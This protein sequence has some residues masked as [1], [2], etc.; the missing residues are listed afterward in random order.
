V[1]TKL[2][3]PPQWINADHATV[4]SDGK[5]ELSFTIDPLSEL[6]HF[7]LEK[8]TGSGIFQQIA[9]PVPVNGKINY[10]DIQADTKSINYYRL[11]ALNSCNLPV[12]ISNLASN[13][14]LSYSMSGNNIVLSWNPYKKWLGIVSGY[15]IFIDTGNGFV[16]KTI[17]SGSD[18]TFIQ[19]YQQIMFD[20]KADHICFYV[21]ASESSNPYNVE[22]ESVSAPIC[23]PP[24][25]LI[26]VP[27]VFTPNNDLK[28]DL[29]KPVLSFTPQSYQLVISDRQGNVLFESRDYLESWDGT[30][31]GNHQPQGVCLWFLKLTTPS[32]KVISRTGTITIINER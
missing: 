2:K 24:V 17:V 7:S 5:I 8:K 14:V 23:T 27:N 32:G 1:F 31:N 21:S 6:N 26:T 16:E 22:G 29:F 15:K 11:S 3:R 12:T 9:Q 19:D 4:N 18:S 10:A 20:V 25:E 30:S 13:I 28:N